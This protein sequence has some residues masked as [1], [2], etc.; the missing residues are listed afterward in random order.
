MMRRYF[1]IIYIFLLSVGKGNVHRLEVFSFFM[2][3]P[4]Y[5]LA[6]SYDPFRFHMV[7]TKTMAHILAI[8]HCLEHYRIFQVV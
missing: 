1:V 7:V 6:G 8:D 4:C 3:R 2:C 5:R